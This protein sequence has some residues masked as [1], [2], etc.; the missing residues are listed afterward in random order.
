M[1]RKLGGIS[2]GL[3]TILFLAGLG[4]IVW[5]ESVPGMQPTITVL[6]FDQ[7]G[8]ARSASRQAEQEARKILQRAGIEVTWHDCSQKP[9]NQDQ[10]CHKIPGSG[11]FIVSIS[12]QGDNLGTDVFGAAFLDSS[13]NGNY[14][15]VFYDRLQSLR[16]QTGQDTGRLLGAVTAHELGHLLLGS[17]SHTR[18]GIMSPHWKKEELNRLERG[19]LLFS[20]EE[21][22]KIKN[23]L[24]PMLAR[25]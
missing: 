23:R 18:V 22:E 2:C 20:P 7:T 16:Q 8:V 24:Q 21:A 13:G 1:R 3:L 25:Q 15:G 4:V 19:N 6:V 5:A 10:A 12:N 17:N 14:A 9:P 11:Q